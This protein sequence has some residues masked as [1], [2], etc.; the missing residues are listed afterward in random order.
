MS[1]GDAIRWTVGTTTGLIIGALMGGLIAGATA[2]SPAAKPCPPA[3][4]VATAPTPAPTAR[5]PAVKWTERSTQYASGDH[6]WFSWRSSMV[7]WL[8]GHPVPT[9][10]EQR[11]AAQEGWWGEPVNTPPGALAYVTNDR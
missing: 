3:A 4:E 11:T 5:P 1:D 8:G 9:M 10:K 6:L 7:R 2:S